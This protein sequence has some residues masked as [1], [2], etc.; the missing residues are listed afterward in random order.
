MLPPSFMPKMWLPSRVF[1]RYGRL[2]HPPGYSAAPDVPITDLPILYLSE[3]SGLYQGTYGDFTTIGEYNI[4]VFVEDNAGFLSVPKNTSVTV[5]G[6]CLSVADDLS[7]WVPCA[8]HNGAKYGF[9]LN[10]APPLNDLNGY[11]W[12]LDMTTLTP[13]EGAGCIPIAPNL[14]MPIPCVAYKGTQYGFTL[15]FYKNEYDSEG[16]YWKMDMSTLVAK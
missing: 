14:S 3:S 5:M 10:F 6:D 9:T 13:G 12:N 7:I 16:L 1:S 15:D 2:L 8:E 4:A 11:Y